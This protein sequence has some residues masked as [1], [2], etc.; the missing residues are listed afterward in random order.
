MS[1]KRPKIV[2]GY[3]ALTA[4]RLL[5]NKAQYSKLGQSVFPEQQGLSSSSDGYNTDTLQN[6]PS[7]ILGLLLQ[8][9][10]QPGMQCAPHVMATV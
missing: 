2:A 6:F 10:S 4:D 8:I 9:N 3:R 5:V 7:R 1:W